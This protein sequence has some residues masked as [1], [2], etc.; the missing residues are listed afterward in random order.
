MASVPGLDIQAEVIAP[1]RFGDGVLLPAGTVLHGT[2]MNRHATGLGI[3]HERASVW[4]EFHEYELPNHRVY[5]IIARVEKVDNA[6][7]SVT[8]DGKIRGILAADS[9][10][11]VLNGVWT[12]PSRSLFQR[13][14][15]GLTGASEK[16]WRSYAP[17]P[18]GAI[19]LFGLRCALFRLPDPEIRLPA[20]T[21][22]QLRLVNLPTDVPLYELP[23]EIQVPERIASALTALP[24]EVTK[25]EGAPVKDIINV[26]FDGTAEQ[27][28]NAFL[29]AGWST[30][31]DITKHSVAEEY[32]AFTQKR[33]YARAPASLLLYRNRE[34]DFVF[35]K[36]LNNV[37]YR[38][39]IRV[40]KED[41]NGH[42][43]WVGAATHD[44]G[45]GADLRKVKFT[46]R[47]DRAIDEERQ[48]VVDDIAYSGCST[49]TGYVARPDIKAPGIMT[50]KRLAYLELHSCEATRRGLTFSTPVGRTARLAAIARRIIL[51]SRQYVERENS[52]FWMYRVTKWTRAA[53]RKAPPA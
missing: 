24:V 34:P 50:D 1:V 40:W 39:H 52:V 47:I 42:T 10:Q 15:I 48:K 30:A 6:R 4:L 13:A 25:P 23:E 35:E 22:L 9:P 28:Q 16:A 21:E 29:T 19:G 27:V 3:V 8:K 38:H 46:H 33:G 43:V 5:P 44:I 11:Q 18:I 14:T 51:E 32:Q 17:G 26:A 12:V 20:G 53:L 37:M 2:V 7:E 45:V 49:G 31:E 36:S 41:V